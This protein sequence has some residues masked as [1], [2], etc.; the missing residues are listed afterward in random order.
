MATVIARTIA[1][2]SS[3]A[4]AGAT[5]AITGIV[6]M[7]SSS[8]VAGSLPRPCAIV[9]KARKMIS[10]MA[11]NNTSGDPREQGWQQEADRRGPGHHHD[12]HHADLERR[13]D[14]KVGRPASPKAPA[15][16]KV[17]N[18]PIASDRTNANVIPVLNR[19]NHEAARSRS[20]R[21]PAREATAQLIAGSSRSRHADAKT[22]RSG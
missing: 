14:R 11:P 15:R 21:A 6:A 18:Q 5:M 16:R 17:G 10:A 9:A 4:C 19:R 2:G 13:R 22:G 20:D 7:H 1:V 8:K 12:Q 3:P